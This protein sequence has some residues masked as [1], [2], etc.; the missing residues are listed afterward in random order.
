MDNS[1]LSDKRP[2]DDIIAY[3][4][5]PF[6]IFAY[7]VGL[8]LA[9]FVSKTSTISI[10]Y[11]INI[12]SSLTSLIIAIFTFLF[13]CIYKKQSALFTYICCL[14]SGFIMLPSIFITAGNVNTGIIHYFYLVAIAY[15]FSCITL[16]L[17]LAGIPNLIL[18]N[19]L[20]YL[21]FTGKLPHTENI[22]INPYSYV[23]GF[24]ISCGSV[25]I[26]SNIFYRILLHE[27]MKYKEL[28]S[29][30]ELTSLYNRRCLDIELLNKNY[31]F[32]I[33][34]D[35]DHFKDINDE[36]GHQAGDEALRTLA[37]IA[38]TYCSNEFK[39]YRYGGEEFFILS[40]FD[41]DNTINLV[42]KIYN[43]IQDNFRILDKHITVSFGISQHLDGDTIE[44]FVNEADAQMYLAKHKGRNQVRY[45]CQPVDMTIT[46]ELPNSIEG[47]NNE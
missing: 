44:A 46:E 33:M 28:A 25:A 12:T 24:N 31:A 15:G 20:L 45:N 42:K 30:D 36:F 4:L 14:T 38:L 29:K 34:M 40:R 22:S 13:I 1:L 32:G 11:I 43:D 6:S 41:Y 27:S 18:I 37:R 23:L 8:F 47:E 26:I 19:I 7:C 17:L 3:V 9:I 10:S 2:L 21:S 39:I 16:K 35:I 5:G